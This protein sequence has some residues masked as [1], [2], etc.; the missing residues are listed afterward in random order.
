MAD[1]TLINLNL[2]FMRYGSEVERER[3]LPLGCLYLVRAAEGAGLD[4]DFRDYQLDG[5]EDPFDLDHFCDF[6]RDPAPLVGLSCMANLLPFAVLA[7]RAL[8]E[9]YGVTV[10]LGGVGPK[11][12]EERLLERFPWLDAI[13]VGEGERTL[14][15]LLA[16]RRAGRGFAGV[17]G[18]VWRDGTRIVREAQ[19]PRISDLDAEPFPAWHRLPLERYAGYGLM[20]SR[21]CPW[22][23]TF[24]SVAPVWDYRSVSRSAR[25][26]VAEMR[27]LHDRAGVSLFLFQDE[28][29]V[30]GKPQVMAFCD[31][32][33]RSG[34]QVKWKAF[35]RVNLTDDEMMHAMAAA[36]CVELRFGIESGSDAVLTRI[37]K[38]FTA[39][40]VMELV[41]RAIPI[42]PRVD[43]FYVW[44]F[45]DETLDEFRQTLFQM[46]GFR[47]QGAR[48]LPSLL[49]LLP[50]TP[51]Y[52]EL[53]PARLEFC[54]WLLPEFVFTGHEVC[55]G[56]TVEL[57]ARHRALWD[58]V[59]G[60]PDLFPGFL[61]YDLTGNVLPKLELLQE[62]G[63]Y[64]RDQRKAAEPNHTGPEEMLAGALTAAS[65][66][67]C[68]AHSPS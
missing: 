51:L 52:R 21:G 38:G 58:L 6:C 22:P 61:H 31:E 43:L 40:Q 23:C 41:P 68:G 63:F 53:D 56:G 19:R 35:G 17:A 44:G 15:E 28:F 2:L 29:F 42:F 59:R 32:L 57:P 55:H 39:A 24:C 33:R 16:G 46:V 5:G 30:S 48:I 26:I 37:R 67:S 60:H 12:V 50:Q 45:P 54:P 11:A 47:M 9:R 27:E 36:G 65:G 14:V 25:N 20:T 62:F 49:S 4:I 10:I 13:S 34:L 7:A 1:L 3:H 8:K 18:L 66:D 64:P